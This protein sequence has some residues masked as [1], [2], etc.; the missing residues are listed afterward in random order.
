MSASIAVGDWVRL[1]HDSHSEGI[2]LYIGK[3]SGYKKEQYGI[4]VTDFTVGDHNGQYKGIRYFEVILQ[5]Y[6][7]HQALIT[8]MIQ[9]TKDT[10]TNRGIFVSKS[11]V[12]K[13]KKADFQNTARLNDRNQKIASF[14]HKHCIHYDPI[15][16]FDTL[17]IITLLGK[18]WLRYVTLMLP[19]LDKFVM[20]RV[21]KTFHLF[22]T[23]VEGTE[24]TPDP[25]P[26]I[27]A[28]Y[29][30]FASMEL[31]IDDVPQDTDYSKLSPS[32][33]NDIGDA[34][35]A[36]LSPTARGIATEEDT[37]TE[38]KQSKPKRA[39]RNG[40]KQKH[41]KS[42]SKSTKKAKAQT[43]QNKQKKETKSKTVEEEK[44]TFVVN[45]SFEFNKQR[46]LNQEEQFLWNELCKTEAM[47][48]Y[49][50]KGIDGV[51]EGRMNISDKVIKTVKQ[52]GEDG[53]DNGQQREMIYSVDGMGSIRSKST[54][55]K[56]GHADD[57][58]LD[59]A[60]A[61]NR[62][63]WYLSCP[64]GDE[65]QALDKE[66]RTLIQNAD[67]PLFYD[68]IMDNKLY[69]EKNGVINLY[70]KRFLKRTPFERNVISYFLTFQNKLVE[71]Y[72][73]TAYED[74]QL[75]DYYSDEK[76]AFYL[77]VSN[78][79]IL[80]IAM[81]ADV[82][83]NAV[84]CAP[85]DDRGDQVSPEFQDK[86]SPLPTMANSI[87]T[88]QSFPQTTL[89]ID[90]NY[91][92]RSFGG[93]TTGVLFLVPILRS[94]YSSL[95]SLQL[96]KCDLNDEDVKT[97]CTYWRQR[98]THSP[99]EILSLAENKKIT[100]DY[101]DEL[102]DV[103]ANYLGNVMCLM[104][105]ETGITDETCLTI[106]N[107]YKSQF[108]KSQVK[109]DKISKEIDEKYQMIEVFKKEV[110]AI[111]ETQR[112]TNWK[113]DNEAIAQF[114]YDIAN[115]Y[116]EVHKYYAETTGNNP[117]DAQWEQL[118]QE[119]LTVNNVA[120]S[121][122]AV[123][124]LFD[125]KIQMEELE[126]EREL[127]DTPHRK[128]RSKLKQIRLHLNDGITRSGFAMLNDCYKK[129]YIKVK[130]ATSVMLIDGFVDENSFTKINQYKQWRKQYSA[131]EEEL[132]MLKITKKEL[133]QRIQMITNQ[134]MTQTL[135]N[136]HIAALTAKRK[137]LNKQKEQLVYKGLELNDLIAEA[138][139]NPM[140]DPKRDPKWDK[141]LMTNWNAVWSKWVDIMAYKNFH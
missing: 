77:I 53:T 63:L 126:R 140:K 13:M 92:C 16:T 109:N 23:L 74:K 137:K 131:N 107:F 138:K 110:K 98:V 27:D 9:Q 114:M 130:D 100:D 39:S 133:D 5:I 43:K 64:L 119:I 73:N 8:Q 41:H 118:Y 52:I 46:G 117:H 84:I 48:Q 29:R 34:K 38:S 70:N 96:S 99:L 141:R 132:C 26:F 1:S 75:I 45:T 47:V 10:T 86:L 57:S 79:L 68:Y 66:T 59:H 80:D 2:V 76:D 105:Y 72:N 51:Y 115:D 40:K 58:V 71:I 20:P 125:R 122:E 120:M 81:N 36:L 60:G 95:I 17:A 90:D 108:S 124:E 135:S 123:I 35:V 18:H 15:T 116:G 83:T 50:G 134:L 44:E 94:E 69:R 55:N 11:T 89:V 136:E 7:A 91:Y 42:K 49:I 30:T 121:T 97:M 102:F 112:I 88:S 113:H 82:P 21:C 111:R 22:V 4:E 103:I 33:T 101:M 62:V 31:V 93:N 32:I 24:D 6:T 28:M 139:Q 127:Q 128:K 19:T 3:V 104:L 25:P 85:D 56:Q 54:H 106:L 61:Y 14:T 78:L 37:K 67:E 129:R 12:R 87:S 65:H